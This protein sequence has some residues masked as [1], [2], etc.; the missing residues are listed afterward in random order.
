MENWFRTLYIVMDSLSNI[1]VFNEEDKNILISA[2]S[3]IYANAAMLQGLYN[4][5]SNV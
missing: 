4:K 2:V 1:E 5:T 3:G